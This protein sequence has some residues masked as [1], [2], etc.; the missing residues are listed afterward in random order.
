[1]RES[2]QQA[3][4]RTALALAALAVVV[5]APATQAQEDPVTLSVAVT[6]DALPGGT[7]TAVATVTI[8]DGSTLQSIAWT[9]VGGVPAVLAGADT[10]TVNITFAAESAYKDMLFQVLAEPPID[11]EDLPPNIPPPEGE[12][13]GGLQDRFTVVGVN[14]LALEETSVVALEIEVV[15]SSGTYTFEEEVST[16]LRWKVSTGIRNVG[17]GLPVLLHGKEQ[18]TYDWALTAPGGSGAT[19]LDGIGQNPEFTPD[20]EGTYQVSVTDASDSSTFTIAVYAGTWRGVIT[21]KD[22]DGRPVAD[23]AC[24]SCHSGT[25][26]PDTFTPWAQSG[27]AEI[28]S[29]N[30]DTSTHYS[31]SCFSCHSV[32]YDTGVTNNGFD[33]A[34]DYQAFLDSGM[35]NVPGDN[36]TTML[37]EYPE[38]AQLANIQC[39]NCHGPQ[40]GNAHMIGGGVRENLSSDLCGSCHGEPARHGRFQQWQLSGHANYELAISEGEDGACAR[41]HTGN[42]FLAWVPVLLDDDPNTDPLADVEVTWASHEIHPVT[43]QACHDPHAVGTVSGDENNATVRITGN[44]PPLLAGFTAETVGNGAI[45]MTCHNSRRGLRNDGNYGEIA[46]TT[47]AFRAPHLGTQTDVIMGQN[48]YGI[49]VGDRSPHSLVGDSCV[50]CHMQATPP[51]PGLSYNLGG[52]NHTFFAAPEICA[53]CHGD[54]VTAEDVE[55]PF[56]LAMDELKAAIEEAYGDLM[57]AQF[58]AGNSIDV[59]GLATLTSMA[60]VIDIEFTESHGRQGL[61]LTL[62]DGTE[63]EAQRVTDISVVPP[64]GDPFGLWETAG[65]GLPKAGW[66]YLLLESDSSEGVHNPDFSTEVIEASID[67]LYQPTGPCVADADTMCLNDNRFTVEVSWTD[68]QDQTGRGMVAPAGTADSGIF[69]FF[70]DNNWEMLIKVLDGCAIN[71]KYWVFYA[72]V[73]NV[74]FTVTVTDTETGRVKHYTNPLGQSANAVT[75]TSAFETCP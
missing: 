35:L 11:A 2:Q 16:L 54:T 42:G 43:C 50:T 65:E 60:D 44:T 38:S 31:E 28:F 49:E 66:N 68:F 5:L 27:H 17:L 20:V 53:D 8:N 75:D 26:A 36:W 40:E 71:Q 48:A 1:M 34:A 21:G 46:G 58:D 51:P 45:C 6:G 63:L 59:N 57:A 72:A 55:G 29:T 13:P 9:Q 30:L 70:T 47:E 14:P 18:A 67:G 15:T 69:Y 23:V 37:A 62:A 7:V 32:G 19:L 64:T 74:E 3:W 25:G 52:T 22:E 33:D 39:E 24:T 61:A 73:T 41:C 56:E 4:G 12:F 10:D